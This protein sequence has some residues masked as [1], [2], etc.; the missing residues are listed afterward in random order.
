MED[1]AD[2]RSGLAELLKDTY[3]IIEAGN[4]KEA[5]EQARMNFPFMDQGLVLLD[6][7]LPDA[8]GVDLVKK[9]KEIDPNLTIVMVTAMKDT[10]LAVEALSCGASD[11]ITKPFTAEDLLRKIKRVKDSDELFR[12]FK[13][14]NEKLEPWRLDFDMRYQ[15]AMK[16][17]PMRYVQDNSGYADVPIEEMEKKIKDKFSIE[18]PARSEAV[19][20]LAVDDEEDIR[21]GILDLLKDKYNV[22][23]AAN[24]TEAL[25][26][27]KD[28]NFDLALLDIRLPDCNGVELIGKIMGLSPKTD[29]I[30]VTALKDISITV[31]AMKAGARDYVTKP[32]T[33]KALSEVVESQLKR[34][35]QRRRLEELREKLDE[36]VFKKP[37]A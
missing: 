14:L 36:R 24:G 27:V 13:L 35:E 33:M 1:E 15:Q 17:G 25:A 32:F 30:M 22:E 28:K 5:L 2:V 21:S 9:F 34:K 8:S 31:D 3:N 11:Y 16:E 23:T 10:K 37:A 19:R 4:A 20:I 18:I 7:K 6:I 26:K 29:I 12:Q